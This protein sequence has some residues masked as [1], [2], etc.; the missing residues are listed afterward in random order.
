MVCRNNVAHPGFCRE[1]IAATSPASAGGNFLFNGIGTTF[2]GSRDWCKTCGSAVQSKWMCIFFVPIGRIGKFRVKYVSPNRYL[3]RQLAATPKPLPTTG[4][5][6]K[7]IADKLSQA[8]WSWTCVD[9]LDSDGKLTFV[10]EAHRGAGKRFAVRA[11]QK[12][13]AFSQLASEVAKEMQLQSTLVP[14][15]AVSALPSAKVATN[16]S[17]MPRKRRVFEAVLVIFLAAVVIWA[18]ILANRESPN[19]SPR[20]RKQTVSQSPSAADFAKEAMQRREKAIAAAPSVNVPTIR[21]NIDF[22]P[23]PKESPP[24]PQPTGIVKIAENET[25]NLRA[26]ASAES[27]IVATLRSGDP[28][29][30]QAESYVNDAR[31][32]RVTWRKIMTLNGDTGWVNATYILEK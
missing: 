3:S 17:E 30:L 10:A 7:A 23:L 13:T 16:R 29:F 21:D 26:A 1:C 32:M 25:L 31:G 11:D 8:G 4:S 9:R 2:Y 5:D 15:P 14:E 19:R 28:V 20:A 6:W 24:P 18:A 22:S 12:L 27:A